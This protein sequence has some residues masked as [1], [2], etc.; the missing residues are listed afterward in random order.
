MAQRDAKK[1]YQS[2][3]QQ[4]ERLAIRYLKIGQ[5]SQ[6]PYYKGIKIIFQNYTKFGL[7]KQNLLSQENI[8]KTPV[9]NRVGD[10]ESLAIARAVKRQI[11]SIN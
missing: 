10:V 7:E 4:Q 11:I 8:N 5:S 6:C 3:M 2:R 9:V 1:A